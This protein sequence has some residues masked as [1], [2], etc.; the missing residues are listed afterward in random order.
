ML[1]QGF[2]RCY[3]CGMEIEN[4]IYYVEVQPT[5]TT[6]DGRQVLKA[7]TYKYHPDCFN[8]SLARAKLNEFFRKARKNAVQ[9]TY[10]ISRPL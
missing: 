2:H 10:G 7:N 6:A 8:G 1:K 5:K 3:D 4:R 9:T